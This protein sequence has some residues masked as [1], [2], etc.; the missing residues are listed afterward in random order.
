MSSINIR[1]VDDKVLTSL[2]RLAKRH[3]RSLQGELHDILE[4]AS[5]LDLEQAI[6]NELNLITVRSGFTGNWNR[7]D[8]YD[9]DGR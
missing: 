9:P 4:K 2:K 7:E 6:D 8:I 5:E 1:D 3:H